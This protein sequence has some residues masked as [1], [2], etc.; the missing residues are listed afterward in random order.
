M[1]KRVEQLRAAEAEI[2]AAK[3][4]YL[5]TLSING[6]GGGLAHTYTQ[7]DV[8]PGAYSPN[9]GT[10]DARLS[11]TWNPSLMGLR[12]RTDWLGREPISNKLR[13]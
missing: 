11:L 1:V 5:P 9:Q 8:T 10:W 12:A 13:R 4:A 2:K 6:S 7:Q 3:T